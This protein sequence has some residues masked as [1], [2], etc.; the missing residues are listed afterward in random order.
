MSN[1]NPSQ[2][3]SVDKNVSCD[4]MPRTQSLRGFVV[5]RRV[6]RRASFAETP[7]GSQRI[8]CSPV[9]SDECTTVPCRRPFLPS[10]S[11]ATAYSARFFRNFGIFGFSN[12]CILRF[13]RFCAFSDLPVLRF[14]GSEILRIFD[15][16]Y[17]I[18]PS[19]APSSKS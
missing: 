9:L 12:S 2:G 18:A 1:S 5:I 6:F 10:T 3:M 14:S 19:S 15:S 4:H 13:L 11:P 17:S 8:N 7:P 16:S